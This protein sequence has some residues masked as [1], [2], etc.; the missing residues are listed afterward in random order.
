MSQRTLLVCLA[1]VGMVGCG[2]RLGGVGEHVP[3]T[4]Q[5]IRIRTF[6]NHTRENG[7]DVHLRR[8]LE[9][10]FRRH[11]ALRVVSD[12]D[13]D[14]E[15]SGDI[16]RFTTQPVAFSAT[17]EAVQYQGIMHVGMRLVERAT[18]RV[19]HETK[20]LQETQDFGAV[21]DVVVTSS[22]HFQRGTLDARDLPNLTAVQLTEARRRE[23][24]R[25]LVDQLAR[26]LYLQVMEGF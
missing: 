17:D 21:S 9:D 12:G 13:A 20:L 5:T 19:L 1:L 18:G 4:A 24:M 23:A 26:D 15:L 16:R 11:G 14:L 25:E 10:E 2:Y 7:L 8:A 3:S 22:P 6:R